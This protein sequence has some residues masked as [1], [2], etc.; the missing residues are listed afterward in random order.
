MKVLESF[1]YPYVSLQVISKSVRRIMAEV[2]GVVE[3]LKVEEIEDNGVPQSQA[4]DDLGMSYLD[5]L[6][7]GSIPS[8]PEW[9]DLCAELSDDECSALVPVF[10]NGGALDIVVPRCLE[11]CS[12]CKDVTESSNA[13]SSTMT[14]QVG[15]PGL[16][17]FLFQ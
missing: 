10:Q 9:P 12:I 2:D 11:H 14:M 17:H 7:T 5:D 16:F 8:I 3:T 15:A 6:D 13:M 1:A 4:S